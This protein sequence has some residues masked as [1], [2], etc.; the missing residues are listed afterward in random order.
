MAS[1]RLQRDYALWMMTR[2][3]EL[4]VNVLDE[5]QKLQAEQGLYQICLAGLQHYE[6][7]A[8]RMR[9]RL[10]PSPN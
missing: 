1:E 10:K 6:V 5:D 3:I 7:Q 8:D 4:L 9:R 2:S